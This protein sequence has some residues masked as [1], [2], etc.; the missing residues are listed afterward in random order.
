[1]AN[2]KNTPSEMF[3]RSIHE[4]IEAIERKRGAL[5][6]LAARMLEEIGE[7]EG[8]ELL[9][10]GRAADDPAR[11]L[12]V[13]G[14]QALSLSFQILNLVEEFVANEARRI[15]ESTPGMPAEAGLFA[16]YLGRL[17]ESGLSP[18][19]LRAVLRE[20]VVEPVFT[21]H[22][23][24]AKRWPVLGLHRELYQLLPELGEDSAGFSARRAEERARAV[25]ERLWRTGEIFFQKPGIGDELDNLLFYLQEVLP[26][27][28][29]GMDRRLRDAWWTTGCG[30][31]REEPPLPRISFGTWVG[32]D[33]DGHPLVT[34][35]VTAETL[36]RL[37]EAARRVLDGELRVLEDS[38]RFATDAQPLPAFLRKALRAR[39]GGALPGEPWRAWIRSLRER[40]APDHPEAYA[41]PE[42]LADDL[43][44]LG[45]ALREVRGGELV[46]QLV[47]PVLRQVEV[48]GLHLARLD[49]RQNSA[50]HERAFAQILEAAGLEEGKG[51]LG[52]GEEE[53]HAFVEAELQSPRPFLQ[54]WTEVGAEASGVLDCYRV[55][56]SHLDRHG[57]AGLGS[58]IVSMT[59]SLTDLLMVYLLGRET[60]LTR[61]ATGE[62]TARLP[63]VPLFETLDDLERAPGILD[64][65]LRHPV[66]RRSLQAIAAEDSQYRSARGQ[67]VQPVMI[68]YSDSNKDGGIVASQWALY[69]AQREL[70]AV[71]RKHGVVLR[72]FHGRGG[73]VGRGA[74]PTHRFVEALPF[75]ALKGGLR[76]TEQGEVIGQKFNNRETA[77]WNLELLTA[78]TMA[79][80]AE[81]PHPAIDAA[82]EERV[83]ALADRSRQAYRE[84]LETPDFLS[85]YR[86]ATPLDVLEHSR[87]GSRPSRRTGT[88]TLADLRAI[89]W[90]FSWNQ[91]RF[92]LPGWYGVGSGFA[93]LRKERPDDYEALRAG[94]G[95][96]PFLRYLLFN[97]EASHASASPD[98]MR[99]YAAMVEEGT[100]R[101]RFLGRI[102]TEYRR[103]GRELKTLLGGNLAERRPRFLETLRARDHGLQRLHR[104]QIRQLQAWRAALAARRRREAD[105]LLG[106]ILYTIN[107]IAAGLRT[108]G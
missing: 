79:V 55:L 52:W 17:R 23:T 27:A 58:L 95:A 18:R 22:P 3:R 64:A 50:Y 101:E 31:A 6:G 39:T 36:V 46:R 62:L 106:E 74:G 28:V 45:K 47:D 96:W 15:R 69:R 53:R 21:K 33:R 2:P 11:E 54:P 67:P 59:R 88:S 78:G 24:E 63:V 81:D 103:T 25:L 9:R 42:E 86:Q 61:G 38:L 104:E 8:A 43:R 108:T 98:L 7:R 1:M 68:G 4:G 102:E 26:E 84:L 5:L 94:V 29:A 105:R 48:F 76:L 70:L 40:L 72:F 12:S 49:V 51:F 93:R 75:G 10:N 14:V 30:D 99:E 60:G 65:F 32:G 71:G 82:T 34:A 37:R 13:K 107:A 80:T 41:R 16:F 35:E 73:T 19:R 90:V 20:T 83:Q 89:P 56:T 97:V 57:R 92:Y 87:I 100:V 77:S 66:T 91:S 44:L 85:F